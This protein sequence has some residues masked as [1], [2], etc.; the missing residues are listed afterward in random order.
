MWVVLG[1]V[2]LWGILSPRSLWSTTKAWQYRNP[3]AVEPSDTA[4]ALCRWGSVAAL[5]LF[6]VITFTILSGPR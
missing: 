5:A 3:D 2:L 6:A 1:P 4:Y